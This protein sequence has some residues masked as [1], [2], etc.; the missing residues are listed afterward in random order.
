MMKNRG[1]RHWLCMNKLHTM[2]YWMEISSIDY[3]L[4]QFD[5]AVSIAREHYTEY[6]KERDEYRKTMA[7]GIRSAK[8]ND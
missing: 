4:E 6:L 8:E 1:S 3:T 5:T 7:S 2:A